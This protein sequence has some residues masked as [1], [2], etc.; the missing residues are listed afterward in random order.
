MLENE[1][2]LSLKFNK[3]SFLDFQTKSNAKITV[4]CVRKKLHHM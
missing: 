3:T 1:L 2:T 4:I